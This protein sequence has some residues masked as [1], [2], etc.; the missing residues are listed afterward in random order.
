LHHSRNA[1]SSFYAS[2][3]QWE[4]IFQQ[5]LRILHFLMGKTIALGI[6]SLASAAVRL[7]IRSISGD[8]PMFRPHIPQTP[9]NSP[10]FDLAQWRRNPLL[11]GIISALIV[12]LLGLVVREQSIPPVTSLLLQD[13][14]AS[15]QQQ[16]EFWQQLC[17]V[18]AS[19]LRF[20]DWH[21]D[22]LFADR[23]EV[24]RD[25]RYRQANSEL[26]DCTLPDDL[27]Q[28]DL[29]KQRGTSLSRAID[30]AADHIQA[31]QHQG[32]TTPVVITI[33]LH[34]T[35]PVLGQPDDAERLAQALQ[36][37]QPN[38]ILRIIGPQGTLTDQLQAG[39]RSVVNARFCPRNSMQTCIEEAFQH[40]RQL[41]NSS[42]A[43]MSSL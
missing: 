12:V 13:V 35:E 25:A 3:L 20:G 39:L 10:A 2:T 22:I 29:G 1:R 6:S 19:H 18:R 43:D 34:E 31:L 7:L 9:Q 16:T 28:F 30:L 41:A 4:Q 36:R 33:G 5:S 27:A 40:T 14:S 26:A 8:E 38:S 15:A 23:P 21:T 32:I 42:K 11:L 37:L 24:I 17:Q